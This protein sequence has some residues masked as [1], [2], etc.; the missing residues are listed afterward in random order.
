[1][2][3]EE[4]KTTIGSWVQGLE[5]PENKQFLEVIVPATSLHAFAKQLK[6]SLTVKIACPAR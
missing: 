5:F 6:E 4:L 3:N 1:M 2:T